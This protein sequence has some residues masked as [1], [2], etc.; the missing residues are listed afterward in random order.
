M[1]L[2]ANCYWQ[3]SMLSNQISINDGQYKVA[4]GKDD[5]NF[6]VIDNG[7]TQIIEVNN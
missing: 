1:F 2:A 5:R 6:T 7:L 3:E 4:V